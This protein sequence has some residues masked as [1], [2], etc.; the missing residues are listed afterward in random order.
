MIHI[1]R[2]LQELK[3]GNLKMSKNEHVTW[4]RLNTTNRSKTTDKIEL[5]E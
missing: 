4:I 5:H 2:L 3:E 1:N